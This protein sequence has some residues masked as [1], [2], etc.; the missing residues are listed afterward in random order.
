VNAA[1]VMSAPR[2]RAMSASAPRAMPADGAMSA[3]RP[4]PPAQNLTTPVA[5][6]P[7]PAKV[8]GWFSWFSQ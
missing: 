2:S 1:R 6:A 8:G 7:P 5:L 3:A 4:M